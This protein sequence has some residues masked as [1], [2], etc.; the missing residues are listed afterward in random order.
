M[1]WCRARRARPVPR[2]SSAREA[3]RSPPLAWPASSL[4]EARATAPSARWG[5]ISR[6]PRRPPV[7]FGATL[8]HLSACLISLVD[9]CVQQPRWHVRCHARHQLGLLHGLP[10]RYPGLSFLRLRSPASVHLRFCLL[11]RPLWRRR[12]DFGLV[13]RAMRYAFLHQAVCCPLC[14]Q[15][16]TRLT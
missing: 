15:L 14:T 7:C 16:E 2:V 10:S 9:V 5:S 4:L 6:C 3:W 8:L 12:F 11:C 1:F 13:L